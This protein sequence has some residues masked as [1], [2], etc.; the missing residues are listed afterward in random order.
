MRKAVHACTYLYQCMCVHLLVSM[1]VCAITCINA[2]LCIY[3]A[4]CVCALE[5]QGEHASNCLQQPLVPQVPL[6]ACIGLPLLPDP[7]LSPSGIRW[8]GFVP[9]AAE[10]TQGRAQT[11]QRG[12][13]EAEQ[14]RG[15]EQQSK[16]AKQTPHS[17][18]NFLKLC[19][20][21]LKSKPMRP[22]KNKSALH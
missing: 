14:R 12:R 9:K 2:S 20:K 8:G 13:G 17:F 18:S 15:S 1:Q 3:L 7:P 11:A 16:A 5:A 19:Y 10:H 22:V 6:V 21:R 4:Q